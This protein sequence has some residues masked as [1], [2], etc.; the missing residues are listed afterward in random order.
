[1]TTTTTSD[2]R[3]ETVIGVMVDDFVSSVSSI[4]F[5]PP[6]NQLHHR[7]E[8]ESNVQ[9]MTSAVHRLLD[10]LFAF[11]LPRLESRSESSTGGDQHNYDPSYTQCLS[12][13][14]QDVSPF[15]ERMSFRIL[16]P[17]ESVV[18]SIRAI[19][20]SLVIL[21]QT[22]LQAK[23][24]LDADA[25]CRSAVQRLVSSSSSSSSCK[26]CADVVSGCLARQSLLQVLWDKNWD[27]VRHLVTAIKSR[28][29]SSTHGTHSRKRQRS[30][31]ER[32][33]HEHDLQ[34]FM[35]RLLPQLLVHGVDHM[36]S[37]QSSISLSVSHAYVG[38]LNVLINQ[39]TQLKH[40][41]ESRVV[42]VSDRR[43]TLHPHPL[44]AS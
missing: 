32:R 24:A 10:S 9:D 42:L 29:N 5:T 33:G 27:H 22:F 8:F 36:I 34:S 37:N 41:R 35:S 4:I 38:K 23:N 19:I 16:R 25:A 2:G 1:M 40:R 14:R 39:S 3:D 44:L 13:T 12:N 43:P 21:D 6:S 26:E 7:V 28:G 20:H 30:H 15:G 18:D 11:C 31:R 17:L